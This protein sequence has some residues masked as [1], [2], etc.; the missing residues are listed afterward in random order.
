MPMVWRDHSQTDVLENR[1]QV[2]LKMMTEELEDA[3]RDC[4]N[5]TSSM[6]ST[7]AALRILD[8]SCYYQFTILR[9]FL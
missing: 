2:A 4:S 1:G 9:R 8:I 6:F 5:V 7:A 3:V